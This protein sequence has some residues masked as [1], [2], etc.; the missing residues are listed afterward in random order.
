[1]LLRAAGNSEPP[2]GQG[3]LPHSSFWEESFSLW[4]RPFLCLFSFLAPDNEWG[5][6][7]ALWAAGLVSVSLHALVC[8]QG[9]HTKPARSSHIIFFRINSTS[10]F[11]ASEIACASNWTCFFVGGGFFWGDGELLRK[12]PLCIKPL[13]SLSSFINFNKVEKEPSNIVLSTKSYC[14]I[15]T[16]S[17]LY[18]YVTIYVLMY[19]CI[20]VYIIYHL[21]IC[22]SFLTVGNGHVNHV[23]YLTDWIEIIGRCYYLKEHCLIK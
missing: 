21:S 22:L 15:M 8:P 10:D 11:F 4:W 17:I 7:A 13:S 18:V 19:L 20:C 6:G 14:S 1:M 16:V 12:P 3:K 23:V 9:L 2:A 5:V